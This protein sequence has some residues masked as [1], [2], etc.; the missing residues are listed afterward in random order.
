MSKEKFIPV[1]K[2]HVAK[3]GGWNKDENSVMV[4]LVLPGF[5]FDKNESEE[6]QNFLER[7]DALAKSDPDKVLP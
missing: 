5:I 7:I 4:Q 3:D 1:D 6:F 2:T